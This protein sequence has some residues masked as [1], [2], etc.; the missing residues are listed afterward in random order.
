MVLCHY[1]GIQGLQLT[2]WHQPLGLRSHGLWLLSRSPGH[3]GWY[4][5][6][7]TIYS[8]LLCST[9]QCNAAVLYS[10]PPNHPSLGAV[11][12]E[13][14]PDSASPGLLHCTAREAMQY[15][16]C[17]AVQCG[18]G[19]RRRGPRPQAVRPGASAAQALHRGRGSY[20]R[21]GHCWPGQSR[22]GQGGAC[23]VQGRAG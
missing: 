10:A 13:R 23:P 8:A 12:R 20:S 7:T 16:R 21:P 2:T 9:V 6:G 18:G 14:G 19:S 1:G 22:V 3:Q 4:F 5:T 17:D 11:S 15:K